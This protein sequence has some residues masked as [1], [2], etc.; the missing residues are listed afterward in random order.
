GHTRYRLT[1]RAVRIHL[2]FHLGWWAFIYPVGTLTTGT[3]ALHERVPTHLFMLGG[4]VL[5]LL[6]AGL[7]VLVSTNT[8]RHILQVM[9]KIPYGQVRA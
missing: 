3:Y 8:V 9:S 5:L 7:W 2:P 6:L 1:L 4:I